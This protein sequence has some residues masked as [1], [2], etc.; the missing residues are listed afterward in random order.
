VQEN[1]GSEIKAPS[2]RRSREQI[3][4]LV[5]EFKAS[6]LTQRE[7]SEERRLA[8]SLQRSLKIERWR[9]ESKLMAVQIG[10]KERTDRALKLTIVGRTAIGGLIFATVAKLFIVPRVLII[11]RGKYSPTNE[12]SPQL[13]FGPKQ[14]FKRARIER[15][16]KNIF[17]IRP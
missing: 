9:S 13:G 8:L 1:E 14:K 5:R 6:G 2:R 16:M 17:L 7:F 12:S 3:A 10:T 11:R 15:S 4:A